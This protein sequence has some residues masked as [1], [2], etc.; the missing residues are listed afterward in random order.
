VAEM[1]GL[2]FAY[3][4]PNRKDRPTLPRYSSLAREDG[5]R[6]VFPP[7]YYDYNWF[8]F[9]ENVPD[10]LHACTLHTSA[11]GHAN[12]SWGDGF[13]SP[14]NMPHYEAVETDYGI[15]MVTYKPAPTP[16]TS[17]VHILSSALP[18]VSQLPGRT[19]EEGDYERTLFITPSDDTHFT[20]FSCDFHSASDS[21]LL[22]ER[23]MLRA[24]EP[25]SAERKEYDQRPLAPFR[26][27][28]W[29]EDIV[30]QSTQGTIGYRQLERLA[31][32]DRGVILL[33]KIILKSIDR[34]RNGEAPDA[35]GSRLKTS[36]LIRF[37]SFIG[38]MTDAELKSQISRPA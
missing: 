29:K 2:L 13:F 3:L 20:V 6:A 14:N 34:V 11:S 24:A 38:T 23:Q 35:N 22:L 28:V 33:R 15:K 19:A 31:D 25:S 17:Y 9:F 7:R 30:C 8:N 26:G 21:Q 36:G 37:D 18:S 27:Q 1:G 12:R 32:S 10:V 4:G 16:G 5:Y